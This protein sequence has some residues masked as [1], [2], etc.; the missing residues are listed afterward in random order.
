MGFYGGAMDITT[1][2]I[3]IGGGIAI[4]SSSLAT[5]IS[6]LLQSRELD[7]R[8]EQD[9]AEKLSE[10]KQKTKIDRIEQTESLVLEIYCESIKFMG[11]FDSVVKDGFKYQDYYS[12]FPLVLNKCAYLEVLAKLIDDEELK[13]QSNLF[14]SAIMAYINIIRDKTNKPNNISDIDKSSEEISKKLLDLMEPFQTII[15]ILGNLKNS[16]ISL[17]ND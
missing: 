17:V 13:N 1:T 11:R 12:I 10:K 6:H 2:N 8:R 14:I 5:I 16:I 15:K 4:I 7:K 9:L 3:L